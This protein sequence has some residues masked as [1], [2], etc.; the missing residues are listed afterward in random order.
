MT[1]KYDVMNVWRCVHYASYRPS[2]FR[3]FLSGR[4]NLVVDCYAHP[5]KPGKRGIAAVLLDSSNLAENAGSEGRQRTYEVLT[6]PKDSRLARRFVSVA[7]QKRGKQH[8]SAADP[9]SRET[10][11]VTS[12]KA[13]S[14]ITSS[15]AKMAAAKSRCWR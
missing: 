7:F 6:P 1:S 9:G 14:A 11:N 15:N 5:G 4:N 13:T 8:R 12:R 2:A 10:E 3:R